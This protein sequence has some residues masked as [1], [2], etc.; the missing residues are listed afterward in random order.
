[1]MGEARMKGN[2]ENGMECDQRRDD[3][4]EDSGFPYAGQEQQDPYPVILRP[5]PRWPR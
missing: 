5:S 1:M 4:E 3:Y 2:R